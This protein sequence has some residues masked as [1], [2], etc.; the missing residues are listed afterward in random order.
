MDFD[1]RE[2]RLKLDSAELLRDEAEKKNLK[3]ESRSKCGGRT[4]GKKREVPVSP[5]IEAITA[6]L[7]SLE[8]VT[9]VSVAFNIDII[10]SLSN[11]LFCIKGLTETLET[12]SIKSKKKIEALEARVAELT[13]EVRRVSFQSIV[14]SVY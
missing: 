8:F 7:A 5:E 1:L 9:S 12:E 3:K 2:T 11:S 6:R 13:E 10:Y 4:G 14:I